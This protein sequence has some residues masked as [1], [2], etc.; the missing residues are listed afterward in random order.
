VVARRRVRAAASSIASGNPS[1]RTHTSATVSAFCSVSANAVRRL[2]PSTNSCTAGDSTTR[3][4]SAA[5]PRPGSGSGKI[6]RRAP[7]ADAAAAR[8]VTRIFS[9]AHHG[10][11]I[12]TWSAARRMCSK[13]SSTS[14]TWR[15]T[16]QTSCRRSSKRVVA[17]LPNARVSAMVAV[18]SA[19]SSRVGET[20][21]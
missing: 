12:G 2:S 10:Q 16:Q 6:G 5:A 8:L 18:T 13:L 3:A 19:G 15:S 4:T 7:N 17:G 9:S 11:Q 1:R 14:S 21:K 20:T